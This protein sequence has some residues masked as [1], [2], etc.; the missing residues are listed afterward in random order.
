MVLF[1]L[2]PDIASES[3]CTR[4]FHCVMLPFEKLNL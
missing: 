2:L 1:G 3:H 4:A